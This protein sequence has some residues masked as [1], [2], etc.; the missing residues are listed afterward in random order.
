M[1]IGTPSQAMLQRARSLFAEILDNDDGPRVETVH[2]FC[3][4][5]LRRFPIEAGI[6]PQSELADEF[7]QAR[8]K[9]EAREALLR[10]ADPALVTMIGL[11]AAQTSEGNAE[12]ILDELL[13]KE[14][15]L[16][17]NDMIQQLRAHFVED[18]GFDPERDP[19]EMLAGVIGLS[20]IHI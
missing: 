10:S 17:S 15:R 9:A 3:Q 18:R 6:V 11:I 7:E 4:S 14:E 16:A 5:V 1:G 2:S 20:L 12:A 13:K 8:L 19:Q